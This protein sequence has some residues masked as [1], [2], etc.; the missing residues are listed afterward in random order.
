MFGILTI[1]AF[2]L[3]LVLHLQDVI[4][5]SFHLI[6]SVEIALLLLAKKIFLVAG[7]SFLHCILNV[8]VLQAA[9]RVDLTW[10]HEMR[11]VT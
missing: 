7:K 10:A 1:S 11:V 4:L 3:C 2:L 8:R 6:F 9:V 5:V